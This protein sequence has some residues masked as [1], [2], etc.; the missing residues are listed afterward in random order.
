[1]SYAQRYPAAYNQLC[2]RFVNERARGIHSDYHPI[3][4]NSRLNGFTVSSYPANQN[5][6]WVVQQRQFQRILRRFAAGPQRRGVLNRLGRR[7]NRRG[8]RR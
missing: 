6:R 7:L 1:M 4:G 8:G 5:P 3:D 2:S